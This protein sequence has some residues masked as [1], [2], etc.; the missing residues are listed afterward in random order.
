VHRTRARTRSCQVC[1]GAAGEARPGC[2]TRRTTPVTSFLGDRSRGLRTAHRGSATTDVNIPCPPP[3][4]IC[5]PGSHVGVRHGGTNP[6]APAASG[7][8]AQ[9]TGSGRSGA[10]LQNGPASA[11]SSGC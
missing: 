3:G 2:R 4:G 1:G 10:S 9:T 11:T 7:V 8:A 5:P 6:I